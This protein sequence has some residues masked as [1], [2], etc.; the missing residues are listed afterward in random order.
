MATDI[1]VI[2]SGSVSTGCCKHG[3]GYATPLEA[4]AGPREKLIYVTCVYSGIL[5]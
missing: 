4:M 1:A 2:Q 5:L 3:P